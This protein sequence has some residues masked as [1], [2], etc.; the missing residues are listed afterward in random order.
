M[1]KPYLI[2]FMKFMKLTISDAKWRDEGL[3][4]STFGVVTYVG[5]NST[6][7]GILIPTTAKHL[8]AFHEPIC[9]I[10]IIQNLG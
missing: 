8:S 5:R 10:G 4:Y 2:V 9:C 7:H 6:F 3:D 1:L